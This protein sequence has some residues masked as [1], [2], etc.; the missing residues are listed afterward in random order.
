LG[1]GVFKAMAFENQRPSGVSLLLEADACHLGDF[2]AIGKGKV[3]EPLLSSYL[4]MPY[5]LPVWSLSFPSTK[6]K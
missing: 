2:E 1:K 6:S 3:S 5:N 4:C